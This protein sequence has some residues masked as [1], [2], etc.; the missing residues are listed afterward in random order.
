MLPSGGNLNLKECRT[1]SRCSCFCSP[2]FFSSRVVLEVLER[3]SCSSTRHSLRLTNSLIVIS[4]VIE[5]A[6]IV[7]PHLK[8]IASAGSDEKVEGLR[9]RGVVAFNYK[10]QDANE[11]L[12]KEGPIDM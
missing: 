12:K 1:D 10:T 2:K 7:A 8:I 11:V 5:Y 4:F 6:K 9:K 3:E